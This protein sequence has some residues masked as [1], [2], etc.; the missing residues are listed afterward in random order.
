MRRRRWLRPLWGR[1]IEHRLVADTQVDLLCA[2]EAVPVSS[3][4]PR[5]PTD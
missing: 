2:T 5:Y 1:D 4:T 3:I